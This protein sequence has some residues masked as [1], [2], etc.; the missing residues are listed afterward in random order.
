MKRRARW[1]AMYVLSA[2]IGISVLAFRYVQA[3]AHAQL[4]WHPAPMRAL[5]AQ[6]RDHADEYVGVL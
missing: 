2:S 6:A 5:L 3:G 1:C 4:Y